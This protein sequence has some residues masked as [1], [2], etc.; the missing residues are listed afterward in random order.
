MPKLWEK[1]AP[2][3][4]AI[5]EA[6][7]ELIALPEDVEATS[8]TMFA[9][10]AIA[11]EYSTSR[12]VSTDQPIWSW[13][14]CCELKVTVGHVDV[15][16]GVGELP[17]NIVNDAGAGIP[18]TVSNVARSLAMPG[19]P[20]ASTMTIVCPVPSRVAMDGYSYAFLSYDGAETT[21]FSTHSLHDARPLAR[22]G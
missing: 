4:A 14:S 2:G 7:A 5:A 1:T 12:V 11:W 8:R 13:M 16:K 21:K 9:P 6:S 10:G 3:N 20:K 17:Q 22:C 18:K 19:L 15:S